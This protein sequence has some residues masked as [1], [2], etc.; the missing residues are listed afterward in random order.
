MLPA[1]PAKELQNKQPP[2]IPP[3]TMK[4]LLTTLISTQ[5]GWITRQALKWATLGGATVTTWLTAQGA[6][7]DQSAA[8]TTGLITALVAAL[9]IGLSRLASRIATPVSSPSPE[10]AK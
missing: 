5:R 9:E 2:D 8:L 3:P 6:A 1:F 7:A 4:T 10:A